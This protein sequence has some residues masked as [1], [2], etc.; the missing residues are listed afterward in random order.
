MG[1]GRL[2]SFGPAA[3]VRLAA[4]GLGSFGSGG[5]WVPLAD[6]GLG[7]FGRRRL[8]S[9]GKKRAWVRLAGGAWVRLA[10]GAWVRLAGG[11][12]V[13]L[14]DPSLGSFSRPELGFVWQAALG[15]VWQEPRGFGGGNLCETPGG[16]LQACKGAARPW[17]HSVVKELESR[18]GDRRWQ[19]HGVTGAG[20][21]RE[22][23]SVKRIV[24]HHFLKI[25]RF[26]IVFSHLLA[27]NEVLDGHNPAHLRERGQGGLYQFERQSL[28]FIEDDD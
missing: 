15:F 4:A 7:S 17:V 18:R 16:S 8:G 26:S 22:G 27:V 24:A 21:D 2:G 19:S 1:L 13:R 14:A 6:P 20:G 12:W 25:V 23:A 11:A 10:G 28:N 9:F 3:W 5:A